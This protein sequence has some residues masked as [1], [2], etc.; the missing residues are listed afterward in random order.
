MK[1]LSA[2]SPKPGEF[3]DIGE[4]VGA[5]ACG[6][7]GR[8]SFSSRGDRGDRSEVGGRTIVALS[9]FQL[10]TPTAPES[11]ENTSP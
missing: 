1:P 4:L 11:P 8:D 5:G 6:S 3:I 2:L 7:A 9:W 10:L